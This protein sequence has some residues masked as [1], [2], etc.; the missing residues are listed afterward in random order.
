VIPGSTRV[1]DGA[2][3]LE[4]S[5]GPG[6]LFHTLRPCRIA[7]T[8]DPAGPYGGPALQAGQVRQFQIAGMCGIPQ[9]A[10]AVAAN[11]TA[12]HPSAPGSLALYPAGSIG[13]RATAVSLRPGTTRGSSIILDLTGTPS[14]TSSLFA[15]TPGSV[16]VVIDVSGYFR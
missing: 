11:V 12:V 15:S 14:G 1:A 9:D 13:P 7:D 6:T 16:D 3:V 4:F 10:A 8:R 2:G 5:T